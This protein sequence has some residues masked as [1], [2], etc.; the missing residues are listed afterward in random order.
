MGAQ[1]VTVNDVLDGHMALDIQ[2][3]DRIY[4][5]AYIP[6]LQTSA[7]VVAFL[8]GHLGYPFPSPALFNQLGQRFRRAVAAYA[9]THDIPW[10][11]FGKDD[12]K[13]AVMRA[14]L[15]RQAATGT[16]G[17]AAIGVAQEFQRVWAATEG[18]TSAG[19]PR[20]S[21]YKADRRVTCYYFY[22]WDADFGPAFVKVCAYFPYPGKIWVN[23]HEWA[24]RQATK[25]GI[26]FT[27]LSNGFAACEDPQALQRIC[28]RLGPGTIG[29]F[30][31][32]WLAR[33][34]LPLTDTDRD[35]GYWWET[36]MRQV[37][38]ARTV[39]FDAPRHARGF[40]EALIV[41]NLDLGRPHNVEII[42]GRRVRRDTIG[43][44]RTAID[45]RDDGGVLL[46]VFYRHSR[47]KQYLKDGR[48]MRIE[49]VGNTPATW[50]ATLGCATWM[51]CRPRRVPATS[52][53]C[54][55]NGSVRAACLGVQ[56]LSGSRVPP[57]VR[58][59]AGGPGL[60][61]RRSSGHG[62]DRRPVPDAARR[63]RLHQQAPP[64]LDR[65][66]ARQRLPPRPDDLR[67]QAAAPGRAH[68]TTAPQQPLHP[69][70]RRHPHRRLLHQA[71][72]P[73]AGPTHRRRPAPST[74]GPARRAGHH[75]PPRRRLRDP[76]PPSPGRVKLDTN[77]QKPAT[78]D[79]YAAP[80]RCSEPVAPTGSSGRGR[81]R[82]T[83]PPWMS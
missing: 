35:A 76:R 69:H 8:S 83:L 43:T 60:A 73:A 61:V 54:K 42:F 48:A 29:V 79:R 80:R 39:V 19:T 9:Q 15:D 27:D 1:V 34:P 45:R 55:L 68:P 50:A 44:F 21:F 64:R 12:D 59:G 67:P 32:R 81:V 31:Q 26:G 5:N 11:Q 58:R 51:S 20:W 66:A 37:E 49:T 74:P 30:I 38:V 28:D 18:K 82:V 3:L 41:D 16:S 7:Q 4:L 57:W 36:S 24:K 72:Q 17:V 52:G 14:H 46:N 75:H 62:P 22:L 25:A 70:R 63:D 53:S 13:L 65:R 10:V 56:P 33:L 2:C 71:L 40:F 47:I 6:R 23:G 77:V 78:K